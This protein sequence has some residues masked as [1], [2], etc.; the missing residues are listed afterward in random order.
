MYLLPPTH[1]IHVSISYKIRNIFLKKEFI[2]VKNKNQ[3]HQHA[4]ILGEVSKKEE[5]ERRLCELEK[6]TTQNILR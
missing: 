4:K 1:H 6:T 5:K 3:F 2:K